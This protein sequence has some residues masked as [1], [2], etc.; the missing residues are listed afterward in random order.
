MKSWNC[1]FMLHELADAMFAIRV[2]AENEQTADRVASI[3]A[4]RLG[5]TFLYKESEDVR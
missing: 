2:D 1:V 3:L 4:A 5:A